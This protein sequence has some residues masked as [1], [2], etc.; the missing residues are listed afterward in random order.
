M[1][2]IADGKKRKRKRKTTLSS[3]QFSSDSEDETP[4]KRKRKRKRNRIPAKR[5]KNPY[6]TFIKLAEV[7]AKYK[8]VTQKLSAKARGW[9]DSK[10]SDGTHDIDRLQKYKPSDKNK[11]IQWNEFIKHL[12][13]RQN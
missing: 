8:G 5:Q 11:Q 13:S 6:N 3:A 4:K 7:D 1:K 12:K 2:L 10:D 9:S